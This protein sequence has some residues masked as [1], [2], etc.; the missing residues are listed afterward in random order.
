MYILVGLGNP[1]DK[2]TGT[3]HNIGFYVIDRLS[4]VYG[5]RVKKIKYKAVLGEG[6]I[7]GERV[8]L[9]KPQTYMNLS[10]QS[11][12]DLLKGYNVDS[13][14]IIIIYDDVD[15]DVGTLRIRPSGGAG[16][17]NGMR[18]VIYQ[19]QTEDFPRIRI[20]VGSPPADCDMAQYV[21]STFDSDEVPAVRE[22]CERAVLGV[23]LI[24]TRGIQEAMNR[25]NGNLNI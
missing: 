13:S 24:L 10:G 16:T 8:V 2:Y 9:A 15:L 6:M 25:C 17:H 19:L 20:G 7:G 4:E 21:L 12:L 14:R 3:R 18:S 23:E 1:G 11:V 5:I 22:A